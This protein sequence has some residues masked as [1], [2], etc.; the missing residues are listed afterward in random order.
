MNKVKVLAILGAAAMV[1]LT[2]CNKEYDVVS[3]VNASIYVGEDVISAPMTIYSN[4]DSVKFVLKSEEY[5]VG[6]VSNMPNAL[7]ILS[8]SNNK[9]VDTIPDGSNTFSSDGEDTT[10]INGEDIRYGVSSDF[11]M[12]TTNH[13]VGEEGLMIMIKRGDAK[14]LLG[15]L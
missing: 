4:G 1:I 2:G 6:I 9:N 8:A 13:L 7:K 5:S 12:I 11:L 14:R 15:E 10:F 3:A